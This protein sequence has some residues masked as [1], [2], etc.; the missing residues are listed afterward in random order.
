M[1]L[2]ERGSDVMV[3]PTSEALMAVM[4]TITT[5]TAVMTAARPRV[6]AA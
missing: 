4:I 5:L 3:T 6:S 1:I 2:L